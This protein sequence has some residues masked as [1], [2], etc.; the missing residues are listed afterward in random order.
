MPLEIMARHDVVTD[1]IYS[2][3]GGE[4]IVIDQ[5]YDVVLEV[6]A[7]ARKHLQIARAIQEKSMEE[8][9]TRLSEHSHRAFLLAQELDYFLDMLE[10]VN[11]NV[12]EPEMRQVSHYKVPYN[13]YKAA[14][15]GRF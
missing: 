3:T 4:S 1:R 13:F 6:A 15:A 9:E 14:K 7:Y 5:F 2:R 12:F 10:Q 8:G 11:F